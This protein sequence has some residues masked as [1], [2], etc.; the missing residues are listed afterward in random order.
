MLNVGHFPSSPWAPY[1]APKWLWE[2]DRWV[3][4][5]S[6]EVRSLAQASM[7]DVTPMATVDWLD[8]KDRFE[9]VGSFGLSYRDVAQSVLLFSDRPI[10]ELDASPIAV[11][12]E[13]TTSIRVLR[14]VLAGRYGL[15]L[16]PLIPMSA[17]VPASIPRLLIQDQAIEEAALGRY[18]HVHDLGREWWAWQRTPIVSAVWVRRADLPA[19]E[20]DRSGRILGTALEWSD[21]N[22]G[23]MA[24]S[25]LG[26]NSSA[27]LD[28]SGL[29]TLL[30][31]FRFRL[32]AEEEH[33]IDT[34]SR[35]LEPRSA[36]EN[37]YADGRQVAAE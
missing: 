5:V 19:A 14:A 17:N 4:C 32:G 33:G 9:R 11:S 35:L 6:S 7:L 18:K 24:R 29:L 22:P 15:A 36:I 21:A 3:A 25:F 16:G 2:R 28:A 34:M 13:T 37:A 23:E 12:T 1:Y 31:N 30:S 27:S 20:V 26:N 8:M 10:H